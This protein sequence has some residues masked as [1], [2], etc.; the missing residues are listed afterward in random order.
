MENEWVE[1]LNNLEVELKIE[2]GVKRF[3]VFE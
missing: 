3:I 1:F 2:F